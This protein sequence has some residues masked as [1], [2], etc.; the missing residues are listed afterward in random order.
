MKT[1]LFIALFIYLSNETKTLKYVDQEKQGNFS[2]EHENTFKSMKFS[3][4]DEQLLTVYYN[5]LHSFACCS[6]SEGPTSFF[7]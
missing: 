6:A 7:F 5:R 4:S 1:P 3:E 2:C